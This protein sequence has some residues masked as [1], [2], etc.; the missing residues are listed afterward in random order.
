MRVDFFT[1]FFESVRAFF[2][3]VLFIS[4]FVYEG[5]LLYGQQEQFFVSHLFC[6]GVAALNCC[7]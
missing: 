7:T 5:V 2:L 6:E 1:F 4:L 3:L